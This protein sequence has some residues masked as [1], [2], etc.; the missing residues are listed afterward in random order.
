MEGKAGEGVKLA[1]RDVVIGRGR[2][3]KKYLAQSL[4]RKAFVVYFFVLLS[5]KNSYLLEHC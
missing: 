3:T 5:D 4:S 1:D 2:W